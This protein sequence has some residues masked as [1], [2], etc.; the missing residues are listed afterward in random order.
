MDAPQTKILDGDAVLQGVEFAR[1][2]VHNGLPSPLGSVY[3]V[4]AIKKGDK[5]MAVAKLVKTDELRTD[6]IRY[7]QVQMALHLKKVVFKIN[8]KKFLVNG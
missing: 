2:L 5:T 6:Q 8:P 4:A 7:H 1:K 3:F